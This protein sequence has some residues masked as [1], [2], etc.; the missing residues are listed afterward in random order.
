MWYDGTT[1]EEIG[2]LNA[3]DVKYSLER[4]QESEWK[5]KAV[6][7]DHVE[8]T[9]THAGTIHL[10][11]PFAPIWLT[12]ICDGTGTIVS[13]VAVEAAGGKYD[14][15]FDF[16][17]GYYRVKEWVQKQN[18]TLEPNPN[19][20]GTPP[21]I[22]DV[23]F[24]IIDDEKTA[25]I[26]FE[27]DEIDITNI[28]VDAIPRLLEAPPEGGIVKAFSGTQWYWMGMNTDHP[29]LQDIRVRQAIQHA[30]DVDTI[31]QGRLGRCRHARPWHRA[32]GPDRPSHRRQ[33]LHARSRQGA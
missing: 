27:A 31:I 29:N 11:Q 18:Y 9:G 30:I 8:V 20:P 6:A 26:A 13:K 25:E 3:E 10:N 7:L 16:Y 23:K 33:V 14:G 5:D 15:I 19:W 24:I 21:G 4:M 1:H 12:W 32:A 17:C 28:A 2:E 22:A